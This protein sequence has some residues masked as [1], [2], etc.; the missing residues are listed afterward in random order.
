[1]LC[2]SAQV[3][4]TLDS[5]IASRYR[6]FDTR[7][8]MQRQNLTDMVSVLDRKCTDK[9][10]ATESRLL[11]FDETIRILASDL[12]HGEHASHHPPIKSEVSRSCKLCR[13]SD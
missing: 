13:R 1:M 6:E 7:I 4:N 2:L 10:G 8:E 12:K 3:C 9:S 11:D 5:R